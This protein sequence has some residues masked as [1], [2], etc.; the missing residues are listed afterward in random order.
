MNKKR[1]RNVDWKEQR[2]YRAVELKHA[3]W[4][5]E[6][7]AEALNVSTRA[8]R[9]WMKV[10]REEGKAG[11][12]SAFPARGHPQA[13]GRGIGLTAGATGHRRRGV[14]ISWR[15]LDLCAYSAGH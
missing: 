2:R 10:V 3:G 14:W 1:T 11:V 4:T 9:Q 6:E 13:G 8:V 5:H 7:I 15:G 12:A